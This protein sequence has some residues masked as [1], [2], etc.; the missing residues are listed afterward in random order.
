MEADWEFE[1]GPGAPVIDAAWAGLVD[2]QNEPW[3]VNQIGETARAAGLAQLLLWLNSSASRFWTAKC[4]AWSTETIDP[5]EMDAPAKEAAVALACYID[6]LPR[7]R[8]VWST[9]ADVEAFCRKLVAKLRCV[10]AR[11][12]RAD[13]VIRQAEIRGESLTLGITAYLAGCGVSESNAADALTNALSAFAD[14]IS[15]IPPVK[16]DEKKLQ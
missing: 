5:D 8:A 12:C 11:C 16:E 9:P 14:S 15:T 7:D 1:I 3:R 13:L 4:D 10:P 6:V 2:L